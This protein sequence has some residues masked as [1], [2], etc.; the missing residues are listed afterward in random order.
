MEYSNSN[1]DLL[2]EV[3][4]RVTGNSLR[5][6]TS[7][8][9]FH[10]LGMDH[11]WYADDAG[12][13]IK[14]TAYP[15]VPNEGNS[16]TKGL[17]NHSLVGSTG[18][19]TTAEDMSLWIKHLL[20]PPKSQAAV[21]E[22]LLTVPGRLNNGENTDY[23]FG[24]GITDYCGLRV[25]VHTGMDAGFK[26]GILVFPDN[27][28]GIAILG[29]VLSLKTLVMPYRIA[30]IVL[31]L[32]V[33]SKAGRAAEVR[34]P[35]T[36]VDLGVTTLRTYQGHYYSKELETHYT[37]VE[38]EGTL[39]VKHWRNDDAVLTPTSKDTFTSNQSWMRE[40]TFIHDA[41]G[42]ISS[43]RLSSGRAKNILFTDETKCN[44]EPPRRKPRCHLFPGK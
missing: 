31:G 18:I 5:K 36:A 19:V 22:K 26:A 33:E 12:E 6:W 16:F 13:L 28:L 32:K 34:D 11:T 27:K 21:V 39:I 29:N 9:I 1:Y 24:L 20:S 23:G 30:E 43:F 14:K 37:V 35:K 3:V 40:L 44:G 8:R 17:L 2:G 42:S 10:P 15:Y 41:A 25:A 38:K 7:E 4:A